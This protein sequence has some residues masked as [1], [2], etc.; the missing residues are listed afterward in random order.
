M[1]NTYTKIYLHIIFA[2]KGREALLP[3]IIRQR[4]Y[5]YM[6]KVLLDMGHFP[7]AIGGTENHVH[8]LIDYK[9]A[10]A[11]PDMIRELKISSTKL[12]NSNHMIPFVFGWQRGYSCFSYSASQV[13][14]VK[15]YIDHQSEHHNNITFRQELQLAYERFGIEYDERYMF[16]DFQ[17]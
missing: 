1:S 15:R 6:S 16:D 4:L 3:A 10:Q 14:S 2:V 7:L 8:I 12:I 13:D 17:E 11:L 5:Q 9:P